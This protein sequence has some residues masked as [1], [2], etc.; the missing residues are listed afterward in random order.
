MKNTL[1]LANCRSEAVSAL[2][3]LDMKTFRNTVIPAVR[4]GMTLVQFFGVKQKSAA[5]RLTAILADAKTGDLHAAATDVKESW[6]SLT[7]DCP[8]FHLFEREIYENFGVKPDGHP[9][10]K[11]VRFNRP[12]N[13]PAVG[14]FFRVNG[15]S[16]HEVAVG[17][18]H[19][20]IIEPGHFRFQCAG[21]EVFHLEIA[22]GFQH[23]GIEKHLIG[24]PD[25]K[26]PHYMETIAGDTTIGHATAYAHAIE[27]LGECTV[28]PRAQMIRAI[29]LELERLANHTGDLGALAGD[30]GFLP[31][32]SYCG[33]LRGDFLNMTAAI[34]GNRFGRNIVRPGGVLK[35][36]T[37][38]LAR[39][40][41]EKLEKTLALVESAVDILWDSATVRARFEETGV[42]SKHHCSELGLTGVVQRACGIAADARY[43][44]ASGIFR[45][46]QIPVAT[47]NGGDVF[48]RAYVRRL[49]MANSAEYIK[50]LLKSLAEGAL[51]KSVT[52]VP[53]RIA[54]SLTEGWRGRICHTAITGPDGKL[55]AYKITDPSFFNWSGLAMALR[56]GQISDFP[57]CNKSF[58]LSYCG[59]DL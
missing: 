15:E 43:D 3:V 22:L 14:D 42:V 11:P 13:R 7:P 59:Y 55:S 35:D 10:L 2:P 37:P 12:E 53:N 1:V 36:I 32:S 21:E 18:V 48:A 26:T 17:P 56:G 4:S 28:T 41:S 29:A 6:P 46:F 54:V 33:K 27:A 24:G 20:G 23:R 19:A 40:L 57:L 51:N 50:G 30:I 16:V 5:V 39:E 34:C 44:F 31:T 25:I 38:Q 9:W 8:Q 58:N 49:E 47:W 52:P 45:Y